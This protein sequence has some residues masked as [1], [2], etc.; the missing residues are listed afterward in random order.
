MTTLALLLCALAPL[1][2]QDELPAP[3]DE[4]VT[5][6]VVGEPAPHVHLPTIDGGE[7]IDLAD[8]RGTKVL[9]A[10]FASW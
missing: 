10:E 2:A 8:H 6:W 4:P 7:P 9:L 5:E 3:P 1:H